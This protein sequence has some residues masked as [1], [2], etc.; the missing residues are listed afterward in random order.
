M[1]RNPGIDLDIA[2]PPQTRYLGLIGA[3][4]EQLGRGLPD[5]TGDRDILAYDLNLVLTEALVNAIQHAGDE[6]GQQA[7]R[8]SIHLEDRDLRIQVMDQGCGFDL[9]QT[10]PLDPGGLCESGRGLFFI[11]SLMDSVCYRKTEQ[12]NVLD[13]CKHLD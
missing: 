7:V 11:R 3:I 12:G 9:S 6:Q 1:T 13:M 2:L 5:Y 8:V 4:A 10:P